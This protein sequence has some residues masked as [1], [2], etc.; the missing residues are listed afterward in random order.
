V[1][2]SSVKLQHGDTIFGHVTPRLE[3]YEAIVNRSAQVKQV[4]QWPN[5]GNAI[6]FPNIRNGLNGFQFQYDIPPDEIQVVVQAYSSANA[7]TYDD[8]I[9]EKYRWGEAPAVCDPQNKPASHAQS[10]VRYIGRTY[11]PLLRGGNRWNVI[12]RSLMTQALRPAAPSRAVPRLTP[13]NPQP[14]QFGEHERSEP[15][16]KKR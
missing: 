6:V 3:E 8:F 5:T 9:W 2:P 15:R 10:M 13:D 4:H 11:P 14:R 7:A 12:T 16:L 1:A